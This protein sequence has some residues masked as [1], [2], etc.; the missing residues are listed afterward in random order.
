MKTETLIALHK[1]IEKLA[2]PNVNGKPKILQLPEGVWPV[3]ATVVV[4]VKGAVSKG[5]DTDK[6]PTAELLTKQT[7]ALVLHYAGITREKAKDVLLRAFTEALENG[8][9]ADLSDWV[10]EVDAAMKGVDA[11]IA[12]LPRVKVSGQTRATVKLEVVEVREG[13]AE[14][15]PEEVESKVPAGASN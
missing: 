10:G 4:N 5:P 3:D 1:S 6:A 8:N 7:L 11:L 14:K 2:M 13:D 12:K 9:K 15:V